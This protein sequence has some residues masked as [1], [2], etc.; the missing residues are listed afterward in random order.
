ME[1]KVHIL[2]AL[3]ED[4]SGVLNAITSLFR[5]RQFNIVSLTAG[6]TDKLGISR[7]TIVVDSN[8][9]NIEQVIKQM[10]K[11]V[12]ILKV[13]D[14]TKDATIL[15]ELALVKLNAPKVKRTEILQIVDIFRGKVVDLGADSIV[16]EM[17]SHP[18]KIDSFL[19]L[20]KGF[21][22]KELVRTGSTA[23]NRG[24]SGEIKLKK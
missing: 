23:M 5:R 24:R 20:V 11:N 3:A 8:A 19:D 15:R 9:T 13:S 4:K 2:V 18:E 22:I 1:N 7:L 10:Y 6:H 16:I 14:V 17:T 21:G 12:N